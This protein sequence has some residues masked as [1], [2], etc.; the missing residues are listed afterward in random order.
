MLG[1]LAALAG[2][3]DEVASDAAVAVSRAALNEHTVTLGETLGLPADPVAESAINDVAVASGNLV[4]MVFR[5]VGGLARPRFLATRKPMDLH[6]PFYYANSDVDL[7]FAEEQGCLPP[8][9]RPSDLAAAYGNGV[10]LVVS[11]GRSHLCGARVASLDSALLDPWPLIIADGPPGRDTTVTFGGG[12]F[13]VTWSAPR[14]DD[15]CANPPY[16]LNVCARAVRATDGALLDRRPFG[17]TPP[18][19]DAP[20]PG[21]HPPVRHRARAA[22]DGVSYLVL[23]ND[24]ERI[25]DGVRIRADD[26]SI[27][28][29]A[30]LKLDL[31]DLADP[32]VIFSN[33]SFLAVWPDPGGTSLRGARIARADGRL[34]E[35]PFPVATV[36]RTVRLDLAGPMDAPVLSWLEYT[37]VGQG[38]R[39]LATTLGADGRASRT[40]WLIDEQAQPAV[41]PTWTVGYIP[42][43]S[44]SLFLLAWISP[45]APTG[46]K[47]MGISLSSLAAGAL[48][49]PAT[50]TAPD[51][52]HPSSAFAGGHHLVAWSELDRTGHQV[53]GARFPDQLSTL[54]RAPVSFPISTVAAESPVVP[55]VATNGDT[56]LVAWWDAGRDRIF[57]VRIR[58]EDGTVLDDP[59]LAI[60]AALDAAAPG[61]VLAA[62]SDGQDY[63]VAWIDGLDAALVGNAVSAIRIGGDGSLLDPA[64]VRLH[65]GA[66]QRLALG[67]AGGKYLAAV[68]DRGAPAP[69]T[70]PAIHVRRLEADGTPVDPTAVWPDDYMPSTLEVTP[71]GDGAAVLWSRAL[72][73]TA[74]SILA[75]RIQMSDGTVLDPEPIAFATGYGGTFASASHGDSLS[76]LWAVP[77]LPY[78]AW[79]RVQIAPMWRQGPVLE[80][81]AVT[82]DQTWP[83][84]ESALSVAPGGDAVAA[85]SFLDPTTDTYRLQ[86]MRMRI[87]DTKWDA[88]PP[89]DRPP[90]SSGSDA[91][92]PDSGG[93]QPEA[94][95]PSPPPPLSLDAASP[96]AAPAPPHDAAF[97]PDAVATPAPRADAAT[98][99]TPARAGK[100]AIRSGGGGCHCRASP[101][102]PPPPGA[103]VLLVLAGLVLRRRRHSVSRRK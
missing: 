66:P 89:P 86:F 70:V 21:D 60:D 68:W 10:F 25:A 42:T 54:D 85:L 36:N 58:A 77:P 3:A 73:G 50:A 103:A 51:Q 22:F 79:G 59:P 65:A 48:T 41:L 71:V 18:V 80:T 43:Y 100:A 32:D 45:G 31:P 13:L 35:G 1:C 69:P 83:V 46:M 11:W 8:D 15:G 26:R 101:S 91:P 7:P 78:Q 82:S 95:P 99:P 98:P 20:P 67:F 57:A 92:V 61:G 28:D 87:E 72:P 97:P 62:A 52:R 2:C 53:R 75:R 6:V 81:Y 90:P 74:R 23:W 94:P 19:T 4:H 96:D 47:G 14:A 76:G 102:A 88:A 37:G 30:G 9:N 93:S 27:L 84:R 16:D 39:M 24:S 34:T 44:S 63:L 29:P 33:G 5:S 64:P 56:Q 12:N 17:I 40:P 38:V 55:H 49:M